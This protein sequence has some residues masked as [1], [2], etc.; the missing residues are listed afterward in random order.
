MTKAGFSLLLLGGGAIGIYTLYSL[1]RGILSSAV[2]VV[3]RLGIPAVIVGVIFLIIAVVRDR[4][5]PKRN[6]FPDEV[7]D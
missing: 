5:M 3:L 1:I 4:S 2:P 6:D 7:Y